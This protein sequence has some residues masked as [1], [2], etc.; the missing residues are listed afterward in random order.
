MDRRL[1][2]NGV[3]GCSLAA[4]PLVTPVTLASAPWDTRL[5]VILLRGAMDGL[6]AVQP[7]GDPDLAGLRRTLMTGPE[8]GALDLDGF[9]ALHPGF[10]ALK[11]MWDAGE[12]AFAHAVSTPYRDARSHFDGQDLL[13]AGTGMD[14]PR[15]ARTTGWLNRFLQDM[16]GVQLKTAYAIGVDDLTILRGGQEVSRW[17]PDA[18]LRLSTQAQRLLEVVYHDDPLF[19]DA[20]L[21]AITITQA[22]RDAPEI[23]ADEPAMMA[24]MAPAARG[25]PAARM[26]EFAAERLREDTRIAAF[27][28]NGWD[29]HA[30]QA[31]A[32]QR[33]L[34]GLADTISILREDLGAEIWG[35]TAVLAMTEF[36]RTAR[37]NGSKGTDHGTAGA[38]IMAGGSIRGGKVYGTWPG[39]SD[40]AL[41]EGRD[42]MPTRDVRAYAGWVMRGLFGLQ[43]SRIETAIFPGLDLE[44]DPGVIL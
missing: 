38:M 31:G 1:F 22:L 29:T 34:G 21:E 2:L 14:V 25:N 23:E 33:R 9:Y 39:L 15:A 44:A 28:V 17:S 27:S 20:A 24:G 18:R 37:E 30:R 32:M 19:R 43:S 36:G 41:Y 42:L 12:L 7:Y 10:S 3:L 6:D 35:K 11:P 8:H 5:V 16:P 40:A 26:A 4:S 13:E